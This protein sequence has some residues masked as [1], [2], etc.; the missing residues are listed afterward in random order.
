MASAYR[1]A[2]LGTTLCLVSA[3]VD[4]NIKQITFSDNSLINDLLKC[5]GI[6]KSTLVVDKVNVKGDLV[7]DICKFFSPYVKPEFISYKGHRIPVKKG[8]KPCIG[9]SMYHMP[10]AGTPTKLTNKYPDY[11]FWPLPIYLN[12]SKVLIEAGYDILMLDSMDVTLEDKIFLMN[13]YCDMVIG[14][15]GGIHHI[16]HSL[17][18]PSII[19]PHRFHN[20][21]KDYV[22]MLHL[23][24]KT[25]ILSEKELMHMTVEELLHIRKRL[26]ANK[27][28]NGFLNHKVGIRKDFKEYKV[29]WKN[30][31]T[32]KPVPFDLAAVQKN[33]PINLEKAKIG[34]Y[35]KFYIYD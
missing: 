9:F 7:H 31:L 30:K 20:G 26:L 21:N 3:L 13:E 1:Y 25:Y 17:E 28:N 11:K 19:L 10:T 2:G 8:K 6:T 16:A 24:P 22:S 29:H 27:G 12:L 15:E 5:F 34:G 35:K 14:Y 4:Q 33:V 18:I 23:D 32:I